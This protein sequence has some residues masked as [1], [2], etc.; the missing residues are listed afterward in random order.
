[1]VQ[2]IVDDLD[3]FL[4]IFPPDIKERLE[5]DPDIKDLIEVVLDLGREV[6]A[7]FYKKNNYI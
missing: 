4:A 6:E 5:K 2:Q 7:R 1:L 3:K